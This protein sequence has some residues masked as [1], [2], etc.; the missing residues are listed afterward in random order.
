MPVTPLP[1]RA[2]FDE[3]EAY[4]SFSLSRKASLVS[5]LNRLLLLAALIADSCSFVAELSSRLRWAHDWL[6][7]RLTLL[8]SMSRRSFE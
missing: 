8:L 3:D 2:E 7:L 4:L 6:W 5:A 1:C